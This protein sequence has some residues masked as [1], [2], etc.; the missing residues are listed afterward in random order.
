[1]VKEA[2]FLLQ[3]DTL[4]NIIDTF[5]FRRD[6]AKRHPD[7]M[8]LNGIICFCGEQGSGK[9]LSAVQYLKR[10]GNAYPEAIICTNLELRCDIPNAVFP[11]TGVSSLLNLENGEYGVIYLIDEI[12]L[13]FNSLESKAMD[14]NIFT[15]VSQQRKQTKHIIGT[16]QVFSRIAKP[17]REQ[18][19]YAILC[20]SRFLGYNIIQEVYRASNISTEDDI[21]S[22]LAPYCR[23]SFW[24]NPDM[25][26]DY[27]TYSVIQRRRET[28]HY[29]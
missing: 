14:S 23:R 19:K 28:W 6:S 29:E 1:M 10:I 2:D 12:H 3:N 21:R 17:F 7:K 24:V 25:Y 27:D 11:Y 26:D 16:S 18:F 8:P 15:L 4:P 22:E 13:E 9:T 20:R 5:R